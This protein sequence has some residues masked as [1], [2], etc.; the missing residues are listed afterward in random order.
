MQRPY[1]RKIVVGFRPS[2]QPTLIALASNITELK[3]WMKNLTPQAP[4]LQGK[5]GNFSPLLAGEG[6][7]ERSLGNGQ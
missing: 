5:E 2:T 3:M 4:S 7:G 6:L 1:G